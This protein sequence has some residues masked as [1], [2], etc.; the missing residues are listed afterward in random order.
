MI[1]KLVNDKNMDKFIYFILIF[2]YKIKRKFILK[3]YI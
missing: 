2:F 3:N 1:L